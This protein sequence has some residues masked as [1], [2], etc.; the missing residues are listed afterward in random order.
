M[1]LNPIERKN[2]LEEISMEVFVRILTL[3]S[4]IRHGLDSTDEI[5][6]MIAT[7]N[8][9]RDKFLTQLGQAA[10]HA[11]LEETQKDINAELELADSFIEDLPEYSN[12]GSYEDTLDYWMDGSDNF[13]P[14]NYADF[15]D[16]VIL[17][18]IPF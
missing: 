15:H 5:E 14:D 2:I 17:D 18:Y 11:E 3:K 9:A 8:L 7:L 6:G 12:M 10:N 1:A 16:T 13:D 4:A